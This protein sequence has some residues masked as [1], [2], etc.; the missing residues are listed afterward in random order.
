[1][2]SHGKLMGWGNPSETSTRFLPGSSQVKK[3]PPEVSVVV[4][5]SRSG[6]QAAHHVG[7][8]LENALG[9]EESP[10][11]LVY[12]HGASRSSPTLGEFPARTCSIIREVYDETE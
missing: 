11:M 8:S 5:A 6:I 1:M 9:S 4:K 12:L 10:P 2:K 3:V 7:F